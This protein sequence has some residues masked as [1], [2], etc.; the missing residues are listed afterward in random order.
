MEKLSLASQ[1]AYHHGGGASASFR[2]SAF[3]EESDS[4]E[5]R[6][7]LL[8]VNITFH[9]PFKCDSD[10]RLHRGE[11][12]LNWRKRMVVGAAGIKLVKIVLP[13]LVPGIVQWRRS[14]Y[15]LLE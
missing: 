6:R 2:C 11:S 15:R 12:P 3:S 9:I 4:W 1:F 7:P 10:E 8:T 14:H 13:M 5:R